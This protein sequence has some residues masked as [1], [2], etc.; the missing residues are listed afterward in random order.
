MTRPAEAEDARATLEGE[1]AAPVPSMSE[2]R[3]P[4][5]ARALPVGTRVEVQIHQCHGADVWRPGVVLRAMPRGV[6]VAVDSTTI[7]VTT[8]RSVRRRS[9]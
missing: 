4:Q 7:D 2:M 5:W 6:C 8:A 1:G 9:A 3:R